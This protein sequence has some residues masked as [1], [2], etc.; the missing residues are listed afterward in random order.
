MLVRKETQ[1]PAGDHAGKAIAE[2]LQFQF[3]NGEFKVETLKSMLTSLKEEAERLLGLLDM[4]FVGNGH[5]ESVGPLAISKGKEV[6][7]GGDGED[8]GL[9]R[10]GAQSSK[11]MGTKV[12]SVYSRRSQ[13]VTDVNYQSMAPVP[14]KVSSDPE[15]TMV[16]YGDVGETMRCPVMI[17][18][19]GS[20]VPAGFK[21]DR[22]QWP[23]ITIE[24][25]DAPAWLFGCVGSGFSMHGG[26]ESEGRFWPRGSRCS[27]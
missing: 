6:I 12:T 11:S 2:M 23:Q 3:L 10:D 5:A 14:E 19:R 21:G 9:G 13:A 17:L 15:A 27:V 7:V 22:E 4:G 25:R 16:A 1:I 24:Q 26:D 8:T 18:K 20:S